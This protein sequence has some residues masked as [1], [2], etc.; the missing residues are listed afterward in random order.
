MDT[1]SVVV[2]GPAGNEDYGSP[3][4]EDAASRPRP[5][6]RTFPWAARLRTIA[7]TLGLM[8]FTFAVILPF[9]WMVL[10]S[11]RT[12]GEI[13]SNPY[14]LPQVVRWQNYW[15]LMVDPQIRFYRYFYNSVFVTSF[16]LLITAV[17]STMA[18]YGF[19]RRRYDF[20]FRGWL[21]ALLLFALMLP[22]QIMYIPQFTMMAR[23]GL[24]NT[25][26]A[27]V[28]LYAALG[29]PVST[30]LMSTYF[31]QLPSEIED[32]A[33]IDGC[34]EFRMFWQVMLPLAR[35]ALATV[36][37]VNS[38]TFWN[39]LLLSLTMVTKPELRTLPAAMMNFVGENAADYAMAAASLVT[40][41]LP[42]LALYL[43]LS[44]KFIEG[45]TAGALKG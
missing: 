29:L 10:M 33:R 45:M 2:A 3:P 18:G 11:V 39:E 38:L 24:L 14:G 42:I 35:P 13:L 44:D 8:A 27:L 37:L 7:L 19:G 31:S 36:L 25:R 1:R 34:S 40:A 30:Y 6:P 41:M 32:A 21:L 12:T 22:P 26:W 43:L 5:R 16:A 17:L 4:A 20:K 28:L 23:Y 15:R 9:V